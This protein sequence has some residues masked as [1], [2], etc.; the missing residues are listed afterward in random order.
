MSSW[1]HPSLLLLPYS[2]LI[3]RLSESTLP[4][5]LFLPT[6]P[7]FLFKIHSLPLQDLT[8]SPSTEPFR[9]PYKRRSETLQGPAISAATL[10][11][12]HPCYFWSITQV[13][14]WALHHSLLVSHLLTLLGIK[15]YLVGL[16]MCVTQLGEHLPSIGEAIFRIPN[17]TPSGY[18]GID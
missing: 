8:S 15:K 6:R 4:C 10:T 18:G 2:T 16:K 14:S 12:P 17:T 3:L 5:S 13:T 1:G 11:A 7:H 9:D